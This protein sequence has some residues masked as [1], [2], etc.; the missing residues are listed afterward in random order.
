MT[1]SNQTS[2]VLAN[3]TQCPF[4]GTVQ[5][6]TYTARNAEKTHIATI[7]VVACPKC[8]IAWQWPLARTEKTSEHYF[9]GMYAG[10][11]GSENDYFDPSV[12]QAIAV[13]Q[14]E[15]V[16]GLSICNGVQGATLLDVGAGMGAFVSAAVDKGWDAYGIEPSQEG[17]NAG[18][19]RYLPKQRI[20]KGLLSDLP[21]EFRFDV[22][23]LWDV[24]EHVEKP[25]ELVQQARA[26]VKPG[27]W[28]VLETGNYQSA[29]RI[30]AGTEWW[31]YQADHR[32]YFSP[33]ALLDLMARA[34]LQN[35]VVSERVFRPWFNRNK[36]LGPSRKQLLLS[37]AGQP[38]RAASLFARYRELNAA[39]CK[40]PSWV[41]SPIVTLASRAPG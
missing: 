33:P 2:T 35:P 22:V 34:G 36:P 14:M 15:F 13:M 20:Y 41:A 26:R 27:G 1:M 4:C 29:D 25:L 7:S 28:M 16:D 3:G 6:R 17:M 31:A 40:W 32:W 21:A 38:W 8:E 24:I 19:A 12:R 5:V 30:V 37:I 9:D 10:N 23:T 39:L 18:N 11:G